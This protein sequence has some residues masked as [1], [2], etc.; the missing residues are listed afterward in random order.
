LNGEG[1]LGKLRLGCDEMIT[2]VDHAALSVADL[3]KS[4]GFYR[5]LLGF[6]VERIIESTPEKRL[7][8]VVG[9][10]G[11]SAR[12][13]HLTSG[14][15]MLELLE[16]TGPRGRP[17]RPDETQADQGWSH[18]CFR[19]TDT[20][21]DYARLKAHGVSF[22]GEPLEYRPGVW[23]VYFRGPDGEVVEL[24]QLPD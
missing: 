7:G 1:R 5:D 4:L 20:R 14:G 3:E 22:I 12:I 2:R 9:L 17:I 8:D 19:T 15:T 21:A 16:Y 10:P 24:R 6:T 18:A 23:I 13:A 11:C